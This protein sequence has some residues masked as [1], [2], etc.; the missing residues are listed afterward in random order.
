MSAT[1]G[2]IY[3]RTSM[4]LSEWYYVAENAGRKSSTH[5]GDRIIP[6]PQDTDCAAPF[7]AAADRAEEMAAFSEIDVLARS[8]R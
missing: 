8:R 7:D 1:D 5:G 6:W 2:W 3:G 4:L